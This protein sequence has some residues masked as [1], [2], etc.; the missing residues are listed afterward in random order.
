[1]TQVNEQQQWFEL[2]SA[3]SPILLSI[4]VL[5]WHKQHAGP[6]LVPMLLQR[7]QIDLL[8]L[9]LGGGACG[10]GGGA[11]LAALLAAGA[12]FLLCITATAAAALLA[13]V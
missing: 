9:A 4:V 3:P 13:V 2:S 11:P 12:A 5:V 8:P 6:S 1:M 7:L 10:V